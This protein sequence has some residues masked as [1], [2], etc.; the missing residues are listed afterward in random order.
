[1]LGAAVAV[2]ALAGCGKGGEPVAGAADAAQRVYVAPGQYDEF[3]FFTSGGFSGQ[4]GVYGLPSG[5]LLKVLPV[6]SQN[7]ENAYGYS[8][9]TK[10]ML[11]TS[12]GFVPWDDSHHPKLSHDRRD[13]GRPLDL[14]QRQQHPARGAHRPDRLHTAE[15]I[16]IPQLG[17]EPR[18]A[19]RHGEHRVR[20]WPPRAS[21]CPTPQADVP[22]A[23]YKENFR[24]LL[25]FVKVD[26]A[27]GRMSIGFQ[28]L[29]PGY[30]YDLARAGKGPSRDWAFFTSYNSE[31]ANTLLEVN[32]SQNDKDYIA[33]VHWKVAE[34]CVA[35]GK[36]KQVPARYAHNVMDAKSHVATS[37]EMRDEHHRPRRR[38]TAPA[39]CTTCRR[40]K[41][42][43]GV[44]V[45]PSGELIV[46]GG[47]LASRDPGALLHQDAVK[48]IEDKAF[49]GEASG[50]PILKYDAVIAGEVQGT[51]PRPAPHRVRR[52]GQ[53]LHLD[54]PL[55][56]DRE[57]VARP[58]SGRGPDPDLL[59]DRPPDDPRR[60]HQEAV[61][62]ST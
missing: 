41:S 44:D 52:Q 40:P 23:S 37:T 25:S 46:A 7:A 10:A 32:A 58:T 59:L 33:A 14:H 11:N 62:A 13:G 27:T 54:V 30:N 39:W 2:L 61:R 35:D 26:S 48:A 12:Y 16:E 4:L 28:I 8:E 45:D 49:D 19:V 9:E 3:Y 34:Q 55:V 36:A 22:I 42:P 21:A 50:I 31:Q 20:R 60:R 57:V 24:G 18:V 5:R 43:H 15:I 29:M 53:R 6:F 1:M 47:K 17:G 56:G 51:R 38:T